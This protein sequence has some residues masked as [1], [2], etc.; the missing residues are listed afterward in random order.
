MSSS[1]HYTGGIV[2]QIGWYDDS[3]K[4]KGIIYNCVNKGTGDY[5]KWKRDC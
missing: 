4:N 5:N 3:S 1:E 2:G